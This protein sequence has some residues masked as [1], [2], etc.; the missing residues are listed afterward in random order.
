MRRIPDPLFFLCL[1]IV[2]P[3]LAIV[4]LA[5]RCHPPET[6]ARAELRR[7]RSMLIRESVRNAHAAWDRDGGRGSG[8]REDLQ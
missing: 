8:W 3:V 2:L 5:R 7:R 1:W 6:S 4:G